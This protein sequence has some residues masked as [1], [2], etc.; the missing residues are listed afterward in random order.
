MQFFFLFIN[1]TRGNIQFRSKMKQA[2]SSF[3]PSH[4][5]SYMNSR[6]RQQSF[7]TTSSFETNYFIQVCTVTDDQDQPHGITIYLFIFN[8]QFGQ[9][10]FNLP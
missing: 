3:E 8:I 1:R 4:P 9:T 10:H 6:H 7:K 5:F 2:P